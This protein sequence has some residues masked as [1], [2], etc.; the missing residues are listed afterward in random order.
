MTKATLA[1]IS[2]GWP[3]CFFQGFSF[4]I[5]AE[6]HA[7]PTYQRKMRSGHARLSEHVERLAERRAS[8][9]PGYI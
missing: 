4:D 8:N 1:N 9:L 6:I 7:P 5:W 3:D 2:L